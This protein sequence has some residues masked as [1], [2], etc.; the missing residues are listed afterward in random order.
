MGTEGF[1]RLT[2]KSDSALALK[3]HEGCAYILQFPKPCH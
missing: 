2:G 1:D 3:L